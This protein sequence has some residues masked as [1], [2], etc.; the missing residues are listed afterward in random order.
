M[1]PE[2]AENLWADRI[3]LSFRAGITVVEAIKAWKPLS[4]TTNLGHDNL[5][6]FYVSY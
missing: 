2:K 1:P 3:S 6:F 4:V 5:S